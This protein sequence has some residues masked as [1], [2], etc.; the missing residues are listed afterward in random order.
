MSPVDRGFAETR[1]DSY[2]TLK[3]NWGHSLLV[4]SISQ[5]EILKST[6]EKLKSTREI[7]KSTR[8]IHFH[9]IN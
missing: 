7:L 6:R 5:R 1:K 9:K 4:L 3:E 8:E 2:C